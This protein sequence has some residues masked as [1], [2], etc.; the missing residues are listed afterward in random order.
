MSEFG[1]KQPVRVSD[2][3]GGSIQTT[4]TS[5][6]KVTRLKTGTVE[7]L[8]L[9]TSPPMVLARREGETQWHVSDGPRIE[10][11]LTVIPL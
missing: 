9:N 11:A 3:S 7:V 10:S 8:G 5:V 1:C 2:Q 4:V 6:L